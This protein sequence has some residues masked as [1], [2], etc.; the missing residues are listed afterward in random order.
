MKRLAEKRWARRC[1]RERRR[2]YVHACG[3]VKCDAT[4]NRSVQLAYGDR[5]VAEGEI[6]QGPIGMWWRAT[7]LEGD[8]LEWM[9]AEC[10]GFE[11]VEAGRVG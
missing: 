4:I 3:C 11:R 1:R 8:G 10:P 6:V 9:P 2:L 7:W 5:D